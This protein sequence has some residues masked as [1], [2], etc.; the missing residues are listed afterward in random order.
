MDKVKGRGGLCG[1]DEKEI[2]LKLLHTLSTRMENGDVN[3]FVEN[4]QLP[5]WQV[6]IFMNGKISAGL[7]GKGFPRQKRWQDLFCISLQWIELHV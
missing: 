3:Y 4:F 2:D 5:E 1:G 7:S 6:R